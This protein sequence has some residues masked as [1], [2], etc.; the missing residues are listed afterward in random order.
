MRI[1]LFGGTFNPIHYGHL[2]TTLEVKDRF[3]L[4]KIY[5]I[6]SAIPPHK[7]PNKLASATDRYEMIK[8]AISDQRDF[9]L[10]D[11]ELDRPG[12]SYSI[13]TVRQ[14]QSTVQ[15]SVELFLIL[16]LDAFLE[17]DTWK[18]YQEF[19]ELVPFIVMIRPEKAPLSEIQAQE[20]IE[21]FLKAKISDR[22]AFSIKNNGFSHDAKQPVFLAGVTSLEISSTKIRRCI[23]QGKSI[24]YLVPEKVKAYIETRGLYR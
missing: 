18:A 20:S 11:V 13:D 5:F 19:F 16:G 7:T 14:F 9:Y 3:S 6:P 12:R 24:Q 15:N 2:R 17:I 1:G 22:Y 10:S 8:L 21:G 4:K 23:S